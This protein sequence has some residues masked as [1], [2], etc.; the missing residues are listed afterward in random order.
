MALCAKHLCT[1]NGRV[2]ALRRLAGLPKRYGEHGRPFGAV[3]KVDRAARNGSAL[4][5]DQADTLGIA[6]HTDVLEWVAIHHQK[7]GVRTGR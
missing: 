7:I 5:H 3:R 4:Q 2:S 1:A 6:Q